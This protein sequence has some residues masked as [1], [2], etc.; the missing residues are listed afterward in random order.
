MSL[1]VAIQMDPMHSINIDTDSTFMMAL[2]AQRRGHTLYHYLPQDLAFRHSRL[3]ATARPLQVRRERGNHHTFGAAETLDL[4]SVDVVLMRQ[5][6][7]FDMAY[8]TATHLLEHVHPKTLVVN[9]PASVRNAPEKLFVT[10]FPDLMPPT[11]ITSAKDEVL[12]FR[13]EY[14]DIIVKP[15]FGNGGSGVFHVKPDDENLG[16]LLETFTQLYREPI[17]VQKY[18]PEIRQGDKRILLVDGEPVGA[19]SRLPQEGEA[20]ANFHAGGSAAKTDLTQREREIC[21]TIGGTLRDKGLVFVGIDVIGD[22]LTEINVTS[23]TGIQEINRL[24]GGA[25]ESTL[26]D[27][28]ERRYAASR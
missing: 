18:L 25:I 22:Y 5:D 14:K 2:E 1:S 11:L 13:R 15:L 12:A 26:W 19:V 3:V 6:P 24:N 10:H 28:I 20:R 16:A 21:A 9:D 4:A 17:I 27:A 8:I 23:P 7:P